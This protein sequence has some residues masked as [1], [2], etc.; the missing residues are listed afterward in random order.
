MTGANGYAWCEAYE[1]GVGWR[2]LDPTSQIEV[3]GAPI[4]VPGQIDDSGRYDAAPLVR[5]I[6]AFYDGTVPDYVPAP[7]T[8]SSAHPEIGEGDTVFFDPVTDFVKKDVG[9]YIGLYTA[10]VVDRYGNDVTNCYNI[11]KQYGT[12]R[13]LK[14]PLVLITPDLTESMSM[15]YGPGNPLQS[16]DDFQSMLMYPYS[17]YMN[18]EDAYSGY[19]D[20]QRFP[21]TDKAP[22]RLDLAAGDYAVITNR[23]SLTYQS[24]I[25]NIMTVEF[26]DWRGQSVTGN[27]SLDY[28][29]WDIDP[30]TGMGAYVNRPGRLTLTE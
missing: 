24:T 15:G 22:F 23:A 10:R 17:Y 1:D 16:W 20:Y 21:P 11:P 9:T 18:G 13:I 2:R 5:D 25:D 6:T 30:A 8:H 28:Y 3:G 26:Y 19:Q 29:H 4:T 7:I 12:I 27:Y 14:R